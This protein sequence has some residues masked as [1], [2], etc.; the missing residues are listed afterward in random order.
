MVK[1][2]MKDIHFQVSE[3][4]FSEFYR[5]YP[6]QG[7]RKAVLTKFIQEALRLRI[8]KDQFVKLLGDNLVQKELDNVKLD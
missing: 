1:S 7:E 8:Y 5:M 4:L 6:G 3:G 2:G